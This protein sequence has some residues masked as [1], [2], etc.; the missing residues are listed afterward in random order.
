MNH[1]YSIV[2][3]NLTKQWVVTSEK[4]KSNRKKKTLIIASLLLSVFHEYAFAACVDNYQATAGAASDVCV[5]AGSSYNYINS[6]AGGTSVT[7]T[8]PTVTVSA[9][10]SSYAA[11]YVA[12]NGAVN[13]NNNAVVSAIGRRHGISIDTNSSATV[14]GDL[15]ATGSTS[16]NSRPVVIDTG[17]SLTVHGNMD[18]KSISSQGGAAI[19]VGPASNVYVDGNTTLHSIKATAARLYGTS[20]FKGNV[21]AIST[22]ILD[23]YPGIVASGNNVFMKNLDITSA[24]SG[25]QQVS[26]P[27]ASTVVEGNLNVTTTGSAA[28]GVQ[29]DS[30]T[31]SVKNNTTITTSGDSANGI[32][33]S[34]GSFEGLG[35]N[36]I[37]TTGAKANGINSTGGV[38]ALGT[39]ASSVPANT[40]AVVVNS[41]TINS[42]EAAGIVINGGFMNS[43]LSTKTQDVLVSIGNSG[44]VT[45]A[46]SSTGN[47]STAIDAYSSG[48]ITINNSGTVNSKNGTAITAKNSSNSDINVT[49][50]GTINAVYGGI[51]AYS[52]GGGDVTVNNS[53]NIVGNVSA[54]ADSMISDTVGHVV[55]NNSGNVN[56]Q[57]NAAIG[58]NLGM[59]Q[60]IGNDKSIVINNSGFIKS[61]DFAGIATSSLVSTDSSIFPITINSTG[62]VIG[63]QRGIYV[64]TYKAKESLSTINISGVVKGGT[65]EGIFIYTDSKINTININLN[66]G[67]DVSATSGI[68][69]NEVTDPTA[70]S[71]TTLQMESGSKLSGSV[72]LGEGNDNMIVK[73]TA[74]LTASTILDGGNKSDANTKDI[75]GTADAKTNKLTLLG[76]TQSLTGSN[77]LNWQTV[78]VDNSTLTFKDDANLTTGTGTNGDGSL[79]GLVL[80]NGATVNSPMALAVSGDVNIDATSILNQ[81]SGGSITGN[82]TNAGT[83]NW[84]NA[85]PG[86][87]L[88][89]TGNYVGTN[90]S[91]NLNT[92]LG[93]DSS[94]TDKLV[95][96]GDTSGSSTIKVTNA[97][98]SGAQTVEGIQ[99]VQVDGNSAGTF[100]LASPVQAGAYEYQLF[101]GGTSTP[102]D[103]DWYLRSHLATVDCK[104]TNTCTPIYRPGVAGYVAGQTANAH[105]GFD[106]LATLHERMGEQRH[107]TA[108]GKQTWGRIYHR[109]ESNDG[110]DRFSYD[111]NSTGFQI[112]Q[113]LWVKRDNQAQKHAGV[114]LSYVHSNADFSD[115][116]R[117]LAGLEAGTGSMSADSIGVGGYYTHMGDDGR[118][119]DVVGQISHLRNKFT[120][121]YA[122]KATQTGWR[123]GLSAEVGKPVGEIKGW[124]FEPQAQLSY[125]YTDYGSFNDAI[126]KVDGYDA[127]TLRGRVGL[128]VHKDV[129]YGTDRQAQYYAIGNVIH[130][131]IKPEAVTI[132][133][134][135]VRENFD[136][137][138]WELGAGIQGQVA[139]NTY[140][141][142]D[143]RYQQSFHGNQHAG[144]VNVGIKTR[145]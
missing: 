119:L 134:T 90:G 70:T 26:N 62:T 31:I 38:V 66:S 17:S 16:D 11:V 7:M 30:G 58:S 76:T 127:H 82:L 48:A 28:N 29:L 72:L 87:T 126:S 52:S 63:D 39:T 3:N 32:T 18:L 138:Y 112:G 94:A 130:D 75:L 56:G 61:S 78:A 35:T 13:F 133:N 64:D 60:P 53:G 27:N 6:T 98:G 83:V 117:P 40:T 92:A 141:Y 115:S 101:Q 23:T 34:S 46:G 103:G 106:Q 96:N 136:R 135:T 97:G 79:Q 120:D 42:K 12:N 140:V 122:G 65:K 19:E 1:I 110:H 84:K 67:A 108:D 93:N 69:V 9:T 105:Q 142:A 81:S 14:G 123:A 121:S 25:F 128:R 43:D 145:F 10:A 137:T 49:N 22:A 116:V 4:T 107:V 80:T 55:I 104:V 125:Q 71:N 129:S 139:K 59:G 124:K 99:V 36:T 47:A 85:A 73:G 5:F 102:T 100:S 91:L 114:S 20:L 113:D 37:A 118:Y 109:Q 74:D 33:I 77:L 57:V 143:A 50:T 89:V 2:W 44:S 144:K 8:A 24:P 51:A 15:T 132:G 54:I 68:A 21:T 88:T 111:Q 41:G 95:V 45:S 131:F 86:Q